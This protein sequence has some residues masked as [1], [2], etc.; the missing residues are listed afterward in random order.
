M[1][2]MK[3]E[4]LVEWLRG[5]PSDGEY[6]WSDPVFCLMGRYLEAHGSEWGR[7]A[8]SEMPGYGLIAGVKP[9][10]YG[11]ALERAERYLALPAPAEV[12]MQAEPVKLL[13][14]AVE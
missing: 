11:A 13:E 12:P 6:V 14:S 4:K 5:Q 3:V 7:V 2:L 9:W 1:E 8:Y 10:T